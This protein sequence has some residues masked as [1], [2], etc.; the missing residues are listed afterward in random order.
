ME[1]ERR[2]KLK[3]IKFDFSQKFLRKVI[4]HFI[5]LKFDDDILPINPSEIQQKVLKI[6]EN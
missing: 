2:L 6:F 5:A 3:G 4:K 1:F